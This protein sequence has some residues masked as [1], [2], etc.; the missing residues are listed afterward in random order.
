MIVTDERIEAEALWEALGGDLCI[1]Q[2]TD[3]PHWCEKCQ[4]RIDLIAAAL[5]DS[6]RRGGR[7]TTGAR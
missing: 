3:V 5:A 6:A 2:R 1:C 4:G 7:L